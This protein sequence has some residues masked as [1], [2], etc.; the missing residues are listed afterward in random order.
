MFQRLFSILRP[1]DTSPPPDEYGQAHPVD[2]DPVIARLFEL[3][4]SL[5]SCAAVTARCAS[6]GW[7]V[8]EVV[9]GFDTTITIEGGLTLWVGPCDQSGPLMAFVVFYFYSA[10]DYAGDAAYRAGRLDFDAAFIA[11]RA[12]AER[13]LGPPI[14]AGAYQP[15]TP[16]QAPYG[17]AIWRGAG[18]LLIIQQH[19]RDD[20]F[21]PEVDI[22]L[23]PWSEGQMLPS[24]PLS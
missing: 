7:P 1:I 18:G 5:T 14:A 8:F 15:Q 23:Q 9:P 11:L 2:I 10:E 13:A 20:L 4:S 16:E 6:F 17:Y 24:F 19:L 21:G 22:W 12:K 3:T